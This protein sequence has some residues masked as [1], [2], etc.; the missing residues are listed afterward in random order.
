[1]IIKNSATNLWYSL[2]QQNMHLLSVENQQKTKAYVNATVSVL[3][4]QN[5]TNYFN[6]DGR[7]YEFICDLIDDLYAKKDLVSIP[8]DLV[9]TEP[10]VLW[11]DGEGHGPDQLF[12]ALHKLIEICNLTGEVHYQ[13]S[14]FN[15][16]EIYEQFCTNNL[17]IP[18]VVVSYGGNPGFS[19][20]NSPFY[21]LPNDV[22]YNII[23]LENKKLYSSFNWNPWDHRMC[24]IALLHFYDLI[25]Y[26]YVTSPGDNKFKYNI[27]KDFA[28]LIKS[29][30]WYCKVLPEYDSIMEKVHSLKN[31]YPLT[32]DDRTKYDDTDVPLLDK[33]LKIP[34][35]EARLNSLFGVIAET[36]FEKEHFFSEK[37][38][39]ELK[40]G[41][42]FFI[43][44]GFGSIKSLKKLGYK[45]FS[46]YIDESYDEQKSI[47]HMIQCVTLELKRLQE[48]REKNP[49]G[50]YEMYQKLEEIGKYN[51]EVFKNSSC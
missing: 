30:S 41:K 49:I 34:L 25:P 46:D 18:K 44:S 21:Q 31:Y 20:Y 19:N 23:P 2:L 1:M 38:Y 26:G 35:H 43:I 9:N 22:T 37:T 33:Y 24:L 39:W 11:N 6:L 48:L 10:T 15:I 16:S 51:N 29:V 5:F 12:Y 4:R 14:S 40:V 3:R 13:N 8:A 45:T 7:S 32:I 50:F 27:E 42:P 36:R 47:P 17:V 28:A